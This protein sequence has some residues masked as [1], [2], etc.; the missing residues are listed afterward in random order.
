MRR[1][2]AAVLCSLFAG[3]LYGFELTVLHTNDL[4]AHLE[5]VKIRGKE[6][7]GYA[8]QATLIKRFRQSDKNV[9]LLNGGDTFQGTLYF[10]V[11]EGLA[12]AVFMNSV[13]Y[14]A[15]AVGNHEFDRGPA[16]FAEFCKWANFPVLAANLE[17]KN[18]PALASQVE[19]YTILTVGGEQ[20]GIVGAVTPD[21]PDI[22]AI[23]PNVKMKEIYESV[24]DAVKAIEG[25]GVNKIVLV[26]HCGYSLEKSIGERVKGIDVVVGGHSHSMLAPSGMPLPEGFPGPLGDYPTVVK[27]S[28]GS[29]CLVL[30]AWEWGKVL[31]RIKL[32]FDSSGR[33]KSWK[34]AQP[35]LVDDSIPEN[36]EIAA[37]I[38]AFRKPIAAA[39]S[40]KISSTT[41]GLPRDG[42]MQEVIA[43]AM[44]VAT[45]SSGSVA[46]F[47]NVGGVRAAVEAGDITLGK[48]NEVQPF[49]N[50][51]MLLDLTGQQLKDALE[52]PYSG[53]DPSGGVL[54]P[55][56]GTS[57]SVDMSRPAGSRVFDVVIGGAPLDLAKTY[58]LTFNNFTAG[59]GDAHTVLKGATGYRYDTGLLD[60]DAL[61]DYLKSKR[62]FD[63]VRENRIRVQRVQ[64]EAM[65]GVMLEVRIAA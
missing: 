20:I 11:F 49:R 18:E 17:L 37:M 29:T 41:K 46:A 2:V 1:F 44:L 40:E 34:D 61:V 63:H 50:T 7:G 53:Q 58:R 38:A 55:S 30:Q 65:F 27:R 13:G 47:I 21:L 32:E 26:S 24:D 12:D 25:R 35:V 23:G 10:N 15:M 16:V 33:V 28:D 64:F 22:S 19:P 8:R 52:T 4:H 54:W 42:T 14:D 6:Y 43:D 9:L 5:P 3:P 48:A 51:L 31:G 60:I 45:K 39:M 57:Y 36:E 56:S 59:G 62:P